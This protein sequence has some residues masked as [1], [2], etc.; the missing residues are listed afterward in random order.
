MLSVGVTMCD[1]YLIYLLS[2]GPPSLKVV[3][4]IHANDEENT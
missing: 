2:Q 1:E 4:V 3:Q